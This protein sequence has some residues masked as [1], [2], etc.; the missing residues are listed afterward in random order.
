MSTTVTLL[1]KTFL[2]S[3]ENKTKVILAWA[4]R[5]SRCGNLVPILTGGDKNVYR[6]IGINNQKVLERANA[7]GAPLYVMPEQDE[8]EAQSSYLA[9]VLPELTT[10]WTGMQKGTHFGIHMTEMQFRRLQKMFPVQLGD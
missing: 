1:S 6:I 9:R 5:Q 3:E 4:R 2:E 10:Y 8:G 7:K